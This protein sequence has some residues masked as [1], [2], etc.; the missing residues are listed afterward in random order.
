M[1]HYISLR[2]EQRTPVEVE[3]RGHRK[4]GDEQV[5]VMRDKLAPWRPYYS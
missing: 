4:T 3:T 1:R 2:V 5:V